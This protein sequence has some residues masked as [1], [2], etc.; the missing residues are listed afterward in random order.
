[1]ADLTN[2]RAGVNT[3]E[4]NVRPGTRKKV[5]KK[6]DTCATSELLPKKTGKRGEE[7]RARKLTDLTR[8]VG[9]L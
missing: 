1:M 4:P 7:P 9:L 6:D 3:V 5:G 8:F 2:K